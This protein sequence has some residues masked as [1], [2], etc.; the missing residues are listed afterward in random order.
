MLPPRA[1]LAAV[2]FSEPSRAALTLA[3]RLASQCGATLHVLHAEDPLLASAAAET[4]IDLTTETREE[5]QR[6]IQAAVPAGGPPAYRDV[7]VGP[8]VSAILDVAQREGTDLIVLGAHGMSGAGRL[9]FGSTTEGVLL[10]ATRSILVVPDGWTPPRPD[11]PGL[12]GTGPIVA[13]VDFSEPSIK[14]AAAAC[15]LAAQLHTSIEAL[16]VVPDLPVPDRWRRHADRVVE[17][18]VLMAHRELARHLDAI[19][20]QVPATARVEQGHV[21]EQLA[22]GAVAIGDRHPILVLGRRCAR[23]REGTPGATA[24]R[25][26]SLARVPVLMYQ[27]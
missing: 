19:R 22:A 10:R 17:D 18:R 25:V 12:A 26:A 20:C 16:H 5:L 9:L 24:Y 21:A 1:I 2:D 15:T 13:G 3:A 6:F 7:V 4:G 23:T 27:S 8:P 14:A 11:T